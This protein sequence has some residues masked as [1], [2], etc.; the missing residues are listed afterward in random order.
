M[1]G[2][3][4]GILYFNAPNDEEAILL[5]ERAADAVYCSDDR[6]LRLDDADLRTI[7]EDIA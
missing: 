3:V 7:I 6:V 1:F 2:E 4:D 5:F